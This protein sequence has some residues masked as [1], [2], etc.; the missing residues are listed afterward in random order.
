M[1]IL[2]ASLSVFLLS[3][4]LIQG[5]L[6]K[7]KDTLFVDL[8]LMMQASPMQFVRDHGWAAIEV[9]EGQQRA[10]PTVGAIFRTQ[11][12]ALMAALRACQPHYIRCIKPNHRYETQ[13][14][15]S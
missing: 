11:V 4:R 8:I 7:N 6:T 15:I 1:L 12:Q 9:S 2:S 14:L 10:P 13:P 5:F 3:L